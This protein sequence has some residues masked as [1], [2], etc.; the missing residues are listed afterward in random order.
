MCCANSKAALA[1]RSFQ[2]QQEGDKSCSVGMAGAQRM[3]GQ[4]GMAP[5][6][7]SLALIKFSVAITS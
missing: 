5:C 4:R 1:P 7:C 6:I 3:A 2:P